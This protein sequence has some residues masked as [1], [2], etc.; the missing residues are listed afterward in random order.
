MG[1]IEAKKT[2]IQ[3]L[4]NPIMVSFKYEKVIDLGFRKMPCTI[5]FLG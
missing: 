5:I 3:Q 2:T 4:I 1:A